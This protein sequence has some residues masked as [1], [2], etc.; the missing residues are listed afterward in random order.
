MLTILT[1]QDVTHGF[2]TSVRMSGRDV[3]WEDVNNGSRRLRELAPD[4]KNL[5]HWPELSYDLEQ[6][7]QLRPVEAMHA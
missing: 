5:Q 3:R 1:H 6:L 7:H 4:S 2:R